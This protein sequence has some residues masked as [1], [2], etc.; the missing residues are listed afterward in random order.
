MREIVLDTET[1]GLNPDEG[2]RI[3]E[4]GG[5][6]LFN[7]MPTGN[8]YHQYINPQRD[9]PEEAFAVHGISAEF[10][11]DKPVFTEIA[12]QF[13]DFIGDAKLVIHNAAF[14]VRFLNAE[15]GW[16]GKRR[17]APDVALDTLE[18]ARKRFPGAQNSLDALCRRFAIDNS[19]RTLHGALLDSEILAEVYLELIGGRQPG[20]VLSVVSGGG[21]T[22]DAGRDYTPP[23][24]PRPLPPRGTEAEAAAHAA[25]VA[26]L[27]EGG[28]WPG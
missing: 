26:D 25:F 22:A 24:R 3:V 21:G 2:H 8:T 6:E 16:C 9:M 20:L 13:L 17:L 18:I 27:A 23:P 1:T 10:L 19:N 4:I 5:V 14:D 11:A 28:L 15:L 7:H 12:Q